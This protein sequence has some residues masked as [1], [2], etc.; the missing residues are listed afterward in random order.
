MSEQP[1]ELPPCFSVEE[2]RGGGL[3][4][5][6]VMVCGKTIRDYTLRSA[7]RL[8]AAG[9]VRPRL[10]QLTKAGQRV[11]ADHGVHG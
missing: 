7:R 4:Y 9:L 10:L 1:L 6:V 11:L 5:Y 2:E 8:R 3:R